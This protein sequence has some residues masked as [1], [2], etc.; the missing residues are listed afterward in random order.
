MDEPTD[1]L[2]EI[3]HEAAETHHAVYR[4]V[5]GED[6][7][8]ASWYADWLVRLSRLPA[9]L[10]VTP[11]RSELIYLLVRLDKE[12]VAEQPDQGWESYYA[13]AILAHFHA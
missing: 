6:A 1:Q 3:L 13:R 4:I 5:D 9:V 12:Y 7:D 2:V 10:G 11:V 8:W